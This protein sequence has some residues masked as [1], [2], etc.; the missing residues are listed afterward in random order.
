[1]FDG[2]FNF[3]TFC[4]S[5]PFPVVL[6]VAAIRFALKTTRP[7]SPLP[8]R[9][10]S[11]L[12]FYRRKE[13]RDRHPM[14]P[15]IFASAVTLLVTTDRRGDGAVGD[16]SRQGTEYKPDCCTVLDVPEVVT[17]IA[18]AL[19]DFELQ[20][21]LLENFVVLNRTSACLLE[22]VDMTRL[23]LTILVRIAIAI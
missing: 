8:F 5:Y 21:R 2:T 14:L 13:G 22:L 23:C 4:F 7:L 1:M 6:L 11:W 18:M 3:E 16:L 10:C 17:F 20:R 19:Q 9:S 15:G 12:F